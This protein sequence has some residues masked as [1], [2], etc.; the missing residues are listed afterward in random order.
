MV[1]IPNKWIEYWKKSVDRGWVD[2]DTLK[3]IPD[4]KN[5]SEILVIILLLFEDTVISF[6]GE[7][8]TFQKLK[9]FKTDLIY[10]LGIPD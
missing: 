8:V 3:P 5:I 6:E 2:P 7:P 9:N 10:S 4:R 1:Y